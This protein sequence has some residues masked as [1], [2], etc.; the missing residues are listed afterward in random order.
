MNNL[1]N[2]TSYFKIIKSLKTEIYD[3]KKSYGNNLSLEELR[4]ISDSDFGGLE[5]FKNK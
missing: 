4:T 1:I 5:S 3:L 2:D